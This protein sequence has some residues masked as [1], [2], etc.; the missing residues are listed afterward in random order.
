MREAD[1]AAAER[2]LARLAAEQGAGDAV[3]RRARERF[4]EISGTAA[5][6]YAAYRRALEARQ[7]A[8]PAPGSGA[9]SRTA[10]GLVTGVAAAVA[11]GVDLGHGLSVGAALV[12]GAAVG[13][14]GV[15]TLGT[16]AARGRAARRSA[17]PERGAPGGAE[18]LRLLWLA[19][20]E[21]RGVRPFL[22]AAPP[23]KPAEAKPPR[24]T[25]GDRSAAAR[26]RAVLEQS[27]GQL[28]AADGV[29]TG[30]T[31]EMAQI[32]QAVH[33]ARAAVAGQPT[34]M[35]LHGPPG[36]GRS[37]LALRAA[38]ELKDQFRGAC[39]V[40]LRGAGDGRAPLPVRDALLHLLNRL[41]APRDQLLFRERQDRQDHGQ[42]LR[43][44]SE[45][46]QQHMAGVPVVIVLDDATDP[47]QVRALVPE[48][49]E[50]LVLVT[51]REPL[52]LAMDGARVRHLEVAPLSQAGTQDLLGRLAE[53]SGL[54]HPDAG[55][56]ERLR[57]LCAGLPLALR[58]AG[59]ALGD[60]HGPARLADDIEVFGPRDPVD[61]VLA[62]R[63][64]DQPEPNRRLLRRLALAGRASFGAA[65]AAAL[66][67][68]DDQEAARRLGEL[69][70]AGLIDNVRGNR[71]R[72]HDL[73]RAFAAERLLDEE[74]P[75]E[76]AAA[77][78]RLIRSYADLANTVVRLVEGK[79]STR[80]GRFGQ[81][82][83]SSLDLALRWLDE[84]SSF[85]T[86]ALRETEGVDRSAVQALLGALCDYCLLRGDLYRLGEISEMAQAQ[87]ARQP[88]SGPD[89]DRS[90]L[91]RSVQ[92]R[93]GIAARQLGD[94][95]KSKSTLSTVVDLY[96]EAQHPAGAA[97]ALDSLGI[98][99]HHQGNLREAE[100]KL[101]EALAIQA[102]PELEEDRAWTMHAL[103]AVLRD[104][105]QLDSA[106]A[107][108]QE[109]LALHRANES[110][111]GEAWAHLQL[112]QVH[113]R[114][115]RLDLG[116]AELRAAGQSYALAR[117]PRGTAWTM[118][119]LARARLLR[120]EPR[121]AARDL[122]EAV[123]RHRA[124]E[125][126]RGEAWT[127][128]YLGQ[129][130]EECG[131]T[132]AALRTLERSRSMFSRMRDVYGLA[133][134]RHHSARVTRDQRAARTGNLRNSGFAR[135]LL[136]D[137]RQDF[138]RIGVEHGEA[139]SCVEL[140]VIDAGNERIVEALTL[141]E[142]AYQLFGGLGDRRGQEWAA[143]LRATLLPLV[144]A[145]GSVDQALAIL[146]DLAGREGFPGRDPDLDEYVAAYALLLQRGAAAAGATWEAWRLGM[147]P[148][149]NSRTVLAPT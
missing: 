17:A 149:R 85:I 6:E 78:E 7:P 24:R 54:P 141:L 55:Q 144:A 14:A 63:Y 103:G 22:E 69:A 37:T 27:F 42:H 5:V 12:T 45:Q 65:A 87:Q 111:Q 50:S 43:R 11:F 16:A 130:L 133:C 46:Y 146:H 38:R 82:G 59:S 104:M 75:V 95:D 137:A 125:D 21:R 106:L 41:G 117:D 19:A 80:A 134:A 139:W 47:E 32:S 115:G 67:A 135:Q 91:V 136:Q 58:I 52:A 3:L 49:S 107:L 33:Q 72:P 93:T 89:E 76:R 53:S 18:Q 116:E 98:T 148:T 36:S 126:A 44:L 81:H 10:G 96:F 28:P 39:V 84:E 94:L 20:L 23:A 30:R 127:L 9:A 142:E 109:S 102:D 61:R 74:D 88:R 8:P 40:D 100:V 15:A 132:D 77:H 129:A 122:D 48:R 143:F 147:T 121:E 113:L 1:R 64:H 101:R 110:V 145:G 2:L 31:A 70:A 105:G 138:R 57:G 26:T 124:S 79:T 86:A 34:V 71:Y 131:D 56:A 73:V 128:Y 120:G 13:A 97:R 118:T 4:D 108:L 90:V 68:T 92:W 114:L 119:Q 25:G 83:F 112:G 66:M 99:L 62:L 123:Q 60:H 35:V 29:F 51:A 140:A